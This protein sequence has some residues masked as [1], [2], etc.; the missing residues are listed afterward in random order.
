MLLLNLKMNKPINKHMRKYQI[1]IRA[2]K[3][4]EWIILQSD[5]CR[6]EKGVLGYIA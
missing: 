4:I 3:E 1:K 2:M 5:S 6:A